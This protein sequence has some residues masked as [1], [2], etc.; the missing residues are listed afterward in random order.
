MLR[1]SLL[2][3]SHLGLQVVGGGLNLLVPRASP[4]HLQSVSD[5]QGEHALS[6]AVGESSEAHRSAT[7]NLGHV[8]SPS[9]ELPCPDSRPNVSKEGCLSWKQVPHTATHLLL[10]NRVQAN[11]KPGSSYI[12]HVDTPGRAPDTSST[13]SECAGTKA[14]GS[15]EG[16]RQA[17]G[18]N[19]RHHLRLSFWP[20]RKTAV[21]L[22]TAPDYLT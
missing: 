13:T 8:R 6:L 17:E 5:V 3:L 1:H 20:T 2:A 19:R 9:S 22:S 7:H 11:P 16:D 18:E 21:L 12:N 14:D 10:W 15:T 4:S